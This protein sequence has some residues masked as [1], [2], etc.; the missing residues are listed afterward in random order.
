MPSSGTDR[1]DKRPARATDEDLRR[2]AASAQRSGMQPVRLPDGSEHYVAIDEYG[3]R[4]IP[5]TRKIP[6][7]K[8]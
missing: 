8:G 5:A 3:Q 6:Q 4:T 1:T 7:P 2:M